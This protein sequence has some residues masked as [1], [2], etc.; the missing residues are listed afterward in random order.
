MFGQHDNTSKPRERIGRSESDICDD[1]CLPCIVNT[2]FTQEHV[3]SPAHAAGTVPALSS[4]RAVLA[5]SGG[6][7]RGSSALSVGAPPVRPRRVRRD[8]GIG[9][10]SPS[11]ASDRPHAVGDSAANEAGRRGDIGER[12]PRFRG[13]SL[14]RCVLGLR[15]SAGMG[16]MRFGSRSIDSR[17]ATVDVPPDQAFAPIRRIGGRTAWYSP[18]GCGRYAVSWTCCA[19]A[20][21]FVEAVEIR[22]TCRWVMRWISREWNS[23]SRRIGCVCARR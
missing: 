15:I 10:P 13:D 11:Y 19:A 3:V 20:S 22:K 1:E 2:P 9:G 8:S 5:T 18:I 17:T 12:G 23:T 21:V 4:A 16:G 6:C 14:A 7:E